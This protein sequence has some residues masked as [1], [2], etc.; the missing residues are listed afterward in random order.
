[1]RRDA[2]QRLEARARRE[3]AAQIAEELSVLERSGVIWKWLD[4]LE[5][6]AVEALIEEES[7][8]TRARIRVVRAIRSE[9]KQALA[10]GRRAREDLSKE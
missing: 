9:I 6:T 10:D 1:M 2:K 8:D 4:G 3:A 5:R 7:A